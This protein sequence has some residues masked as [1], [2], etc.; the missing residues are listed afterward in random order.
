MDRIRRKLD[1]SWQF[2]LFVAVFVSVVW[3]ACQAN[4]RANGPQDNHSETHSS[5]K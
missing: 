5:A 4:R 1:G 3:A 2:L